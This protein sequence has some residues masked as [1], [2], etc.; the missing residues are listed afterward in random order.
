[1]L[2]TK[3]INN[4]TVNF[5]DLDSHK[6][7]DISDNHMENNINTKPDQPEESDNEKLGGILGGIL[8][9]VNDVFS[10]LKKLLVGN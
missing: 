7:N 2:G 10:G 1:M 4:I 9:L 5:I 8:H 3:E 6:E